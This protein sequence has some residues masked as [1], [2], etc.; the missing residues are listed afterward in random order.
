MIR[1]Y[2]NP[3]NERCCRVIYV[4]MLQET[5]NLL[6]V[7]FESAFATI[8]KW[9]LI[10]VYEQE[11]FLA[12]HWHEVFLR[13]WILGGLRCFTT[14][15][16]ESIWWCLFLE[17]THE[18]ASLYSWLFSWYKPLNHLYDYEDTISCNAWLQYSE[19][20]IFDVFLFPLIILDRWQI[21]VAY[22]RQTNYSLLYQIKFCSVDTRFMSLVEYWW[23]WAQFAISFSLVLLN[24]IFDDEM[25]RT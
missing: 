20:E 9:I 6:F 7:L 5:I 15:S 18:T 16:K 19:K 4:F 10:I 12:Y 17:S 25:R 1:R 8:F 24:Q 22:S 21:F 11:K 3:Q 23:P 13:F 14:G 2:S